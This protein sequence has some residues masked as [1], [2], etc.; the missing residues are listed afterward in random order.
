MP[1]LS[2]VS[3]CNFL[4]FLQDQRPRLQ[5]LLDLTMILSY[6]T[7][8]ASWKVEAVGTKG[9]TGTVARKWLRKVMRQSQPKM[10]LQVRMSSDGRLR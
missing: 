9:E 1:H 8:F 10:T 5:G 7:I 4:V 6:Q 2:D 3:S